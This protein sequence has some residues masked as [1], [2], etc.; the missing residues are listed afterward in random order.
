V[1]DND[2]ALGRIVEA[3]T[4]SRFWPETIIFVIEDDPQAGVDHVDGHRTVGFVI[5][6]YNRRGIVDSHFYAQTSIVRTIELILGLPPMNQFD[7]GAAPITTC[8]QETPD[9]RP[10]SA[11]PNRIPLDELNP[12]LEALSGAALH[13]ARVS[14]ELDLDQIDEADEDTFNRVL[15]HSV[16]GCEVPYPDLHGKAG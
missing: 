3:V 4:R 15:W 11:Q 12:P 7:L 13:W 16:K 8:F 6:P 9:L 10:Y 5:S 2:L 1:A 14:L